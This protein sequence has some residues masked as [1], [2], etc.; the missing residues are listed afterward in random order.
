MFK[1]GTNAARNGARPPGTDKTYNTQA[2][3]RASSQASS[4][5]QTNP[6]NP[7]R[8]EIP[9]VANPRKTDTAN[10]ENKGEKHVIIR[11]EVLSAIANRL[12]E[13]LEKCKT[14]EH[15]K[16]TLTSLTRYMWNEAEN[17]QAWSF[18]S[19]LRTSEQSRMT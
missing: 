4:Q 15:F 3:A 5:S 16:K 10:D 12:D 7:L 6:S 19:L 2:S 8:D 14:I 17:D 9:T 18:S 1:P 13:I 11:K